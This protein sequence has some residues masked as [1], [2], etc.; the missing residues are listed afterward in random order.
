MAHTMTRLAFLVALLACRAAFAQSTAVIESL[1]GQETSDVDRYLPDVVKGLGAPPARSGTS[2]GADIDARFGPAPGRLSSSAIAELRARL[3]QS[4]RNIFLTGTHVREAI[5]DME[6]VR[7]RLSDALW[8]LAHSADARAL[9]QGVLLK[10]ARAYQVNA[11]I[12][13]ASKLAQAR[14][15]E[16]V[17][18]FQDM[19][20]DPNRIEKE[21]ADLLTNVKKQLPAT[22]TLKINSVGVVEHVYINGSCFSNAN[23]LKLPVGDYRYFVSGA[24]GDGRVHKL[25]VGPGVQ[26]SEVVDPAF[27]SALR[28]DAFVGFVFESS[29]D[30]ERNEREFATSLGRALKATEVVALEEIG[31]AGKPLVAISSYRVADG[32]LTEIGTSGAAGVVPPEQLR[33]VAERL[34]AEERSLDGK[35]ERPTTAQ[36]QAAGFVI[37][38]SAARAP[39]RA[40]QAEAPVATL[41]VPHKETTTRV[42]APRLSDKGGF[43]YRIPRFAKTALWAS[44]VPALAST[45]AWIG[46]WYGYH[47]SFNSINEGASSTCGQHTTGW[48]V[49]GTFFYSAI[50]GFVAAFALSGAR[51]G[52]YT[53]S[54][55]KYRDD[56]GATVA[57][58]ATPLGALPESSGP[59]QVVTIRF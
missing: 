42:T 15:E 25:T 28:T 56:L 14:M 31:V 45:V 12:P 13:D 51:L 26:V 52:D 20:A 39:S 34:R 44:L 43:H 58:T 24:R 21:L 33:R 59:A 48:Y 8:T 18:Y 38:A 17:R 41:S 19:P 46:S 29:H 1:V 50:G 5:E 37:I 22:S 2:L 36:D 40:Q 16:V 9:Y 6:D 32:A 30:R 11:R 23:T 4:E 55:R 54:K 3:K 57:A 47:C 49:Q 35:A 10:L 53:D 27:E 7:T